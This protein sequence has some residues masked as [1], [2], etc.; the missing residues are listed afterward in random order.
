[1]FAVVGEISGDSGH[2]FDTAASVWK[3]PSLNSLSVML[4][5]PF[6]A[7]QISMSLDASASSKA[8]MGAL[9]FPSKIRS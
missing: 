7:E 9:G 6:E 4:N 1:L 2:I 8:L 3:H 5:D